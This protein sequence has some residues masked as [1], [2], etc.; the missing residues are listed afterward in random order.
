M[1]EIFL[2]AAR[3]FQV[4]RG[5]ARI[6]EYQFLTR[7]GDVIADS[8]LR[9]EGQ[10][11]LK[12]LGLPSALFTGSAQSGYVEEMHLRRHVRVVSGYALARG[13]GGFLGVHWG[14]LVR[15]GRG[16]ILALLPSGLPKVGNARVLLLLP[17]FG[18]AGLTI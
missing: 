7:D 16:K 8:L 13:Y 2:I 3:S 10:V 15:L 4:Q 14:I 6:P 5:A 11:N 12:L 18:L 1:E 17:V 9:Q